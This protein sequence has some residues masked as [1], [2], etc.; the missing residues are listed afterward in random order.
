MIVSSLSVFTDLFEDLV[1]QEGAPLVGPGLALLQGLWRHQH[2]VGS[3]R[4]L[5]QQLD[6]HRLHVKEQHVHVR[7]RQVGLHRLDHQGIVG[8][9]WQ[10]SLGYT[11]RGV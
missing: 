6:N 2:G 8:V 4:F 11:E 5:R 1:G 3:L 7:V 9:F 10:V